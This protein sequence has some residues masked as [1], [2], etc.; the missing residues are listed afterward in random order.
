[1]IPLPPPL[2]SPLSLAPSLSLSLPFSL[3]RATRSRG[4]RWL[5]IHNQERRQQP[6]PR[7]SSARQS[8]SVAGSVAPERQVLHRLHGQFGELLLDLRPEVATDRV[9]LAALRA[10]IPRV[11]S[12]EEH[13][14]AL[15]ALVQLR[16]RRSGER[17]GS[18]YTS[19]NYLVITA[20]TTTTTTTT[21]YYYYY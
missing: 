2:L 21:N 10:A 19:S 9:H 5:V 20:T 8:G 12:F 18:F 17:L 3:L 11:L 15:L 16:L 13:Q 6:R 4:S 1:M 14:R 7:G